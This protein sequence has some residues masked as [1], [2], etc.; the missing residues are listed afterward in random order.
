VLVS[1]RVRRT[2]NEVTQE[3]SP[4]IAKRRTEQICRRR[5]VVVVV[6]VGSIRLRSTLH[7]RAQ[8]R[9]LAAFRLPLRVV[10]RA[11]PLLAR[12]FP[13]PHLPRLKSLLLTAPRLRDRVLL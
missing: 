8:G 11:L 1:H 4:Y 3:V 12:R 7:V 5:R 13:L 2:A 10:V 6:L 9:W